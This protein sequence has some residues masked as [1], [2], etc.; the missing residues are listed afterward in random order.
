MKSVHLVTGA[1]GFVGAALILELLEQ[2]RDNV[3]ALVR[4]RGGTA[5]ARFQDEFLRAAT[6]YESPLE[7]AAVLSRCRVVAGDVALEGCGIAD[8]SLGNVTHVWHCAASL[9]YEDRYAREIRAVNVDG[10]RHVLRLAETMGAET[11]NHISTAYV[12]GRSTGIIHEREIVDVQVNNGYERSKLDGE[13]VVQTAAGPRVRIFR[14][15]II[16]GHSRTLQATNFSGFYGFVRQLVQFRGM[17]RRLQAGLLEHRPLR[18]RIDPEAPINLVPIDAVVHQ[19]VRIGLR[20]ASE[21]IFH[22][23]NGA[24]PK[25]GAAAN[26]VFDELELRRPRFV[27]DESELDLLDSRLDARLGFYRSYITADRR[28]DRSRSDAA[29]GADRS[30]DV[31]YDAP[32]IGAL[33]R[34]YLARLERE[35]AAIPVGR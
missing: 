2:T 35:R 18:L 20:A 16:V 15:S 10:T 14:P 23:T 7:P 22:L 25:I 21:G 3:I 5:E 32:L 17:V 24:P 11:F 6:I 28:F 26:T 29:L 12:A 4:P 13:A 34:W 31:V 1:T 9:C 30:Q 27:S 19:A 8:T 33:T